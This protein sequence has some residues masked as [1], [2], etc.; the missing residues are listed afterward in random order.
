[1]FELNEHKMLKG[2]PADPECNGS[3]DV[4]SLH[5]SQTKDNLMEELFINANFCIMSAGHSV[6]KRPMTLVLTTV[7]NTVLN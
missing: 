3:R 2:A 7:D 1:M 5:H 4:S 6:L